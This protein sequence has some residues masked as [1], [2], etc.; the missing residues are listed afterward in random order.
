MMSKSRYN[1][2]L[3]NGQF[4][5]ILCRRFASGEAAL[6]DKKKSPKAKRPG[7]GGGRAAPPKNATERR[8]LTR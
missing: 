1:I 7:G 2:Y 5:D 3:H 8:A 4:V 6:K